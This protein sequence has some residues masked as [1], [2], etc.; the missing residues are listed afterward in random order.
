MSNP[1]IL[2]WRI[3]PD[4]AKRRE[5][6][7]VFLFPDKASMYAFENHVRARVRSTKIAAAQE[8]GLQNNYTAL[9]T[10][11]MRPKKNGQIGYVLFH[12]EWM[13]AG[14]VGHEI[15]HA[16]FQWWELRRRSLKALGNKTWRRQE[17]F[18]ETVERMTIDFWRGYYRKV[19]P[20]A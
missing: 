8:A 19:K 20:N 17:E 11:F 18:C 16:V 2:T 3:Y 9:T 13:G 15:T 1:A 5:F 12:Q 10:A 6:Y 7:K 4:R 14:V